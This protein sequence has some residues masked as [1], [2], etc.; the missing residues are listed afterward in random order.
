MKIVMYPDPIL[1]QVATPIENIADYRDILLEM[2]AFV[3]NPENKAS[4]IA[5]PQVG[6]S[7]RAFVADIDGKVEVFINP[8]YVEKSKKHICLTNGE[9]CLSIPN[10]SG[11]VYR[12][13]KIEVAYTTLEGERK[14]STLKELNA[15]VFGHEE[16]H[17]NGILFTTKV[18]KEAV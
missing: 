18:E 15:I 4:G 6:I 8:R 14:S 7:K 1:E 10:A 17:L 12:P 13:K 2:K 16:D 3:E 11:K 5:L 9:G